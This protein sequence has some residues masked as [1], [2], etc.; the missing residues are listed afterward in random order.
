[1]ARSIGIRGVGGLVGFKPPQRIKKDF[2]TRTRIR[3]VAYYHTKVYKVKPASYLSSDVLLSFLSVNKGLCVFQFHT[4]SV[5]YVIFVK[6][7][8]IKMRPTPPR[9]RKRG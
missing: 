1:M 5:K 7:W 9:P 3:P 6:S 4:V 2:R 8:W